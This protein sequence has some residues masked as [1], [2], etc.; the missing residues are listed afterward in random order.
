[1]G[2]KERGLAHQRAS[3]RGT[4]TPYESP[5]W[6]AQTDRW[7]PLMTSD[8]GGFRVEISPDVGL[9]AELVDGGFESRDRG[10]HVVFVVDS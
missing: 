3:F 6:E 1:M 2:F 8:G 9:A 10:F 4:M 5:P 7:C